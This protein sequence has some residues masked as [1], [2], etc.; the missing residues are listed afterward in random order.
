MNNFRLFNPTAIL[1]GKDQIENLPAEI[2]S[3][4][5]VLI[6]YG[7]GTIKRIGL[8]D[9][10]KDLLKDF[11]TGE[12][13]GIEPNPAYETLIRAVEIVKKEGYDFLLAVGGGSVIDGTKFIAAAAR[14]EGGD[15]WRMLSE[16]L[17]IKSVLPLGTVLTLPA[18]GSEM[19]CGAVISRKSECIKLDFGSPLLYPK[20]SILDPVYTYT[21]PE[22]QIGN[23]VVDTFIHVTEQYL[24][25]PV[26][27]KIQ[28][29]MA[30]GIL[31]TLIEDGPKAITDPKDYG[32]RANLMWAA[33][34]A[35]NDYIGV[36]VP[37]DWATHAIGHAIT[38][39]YG[40]D[41][42]RTLAVI[43][44]ALLNVM[45]AEKHDKLLQF[46][47]RVWGIRN[48]S[49]DDII[50]TAIEKTAAFFRSVGVPTRLSDYGIG[51][52][53]IAKIIDN[54][55]ET[56]HT[57]IGENGTITPDTVEKILTLAL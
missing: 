18:T 16:K 24:T 26:N 9:R 8:L 12:F 20:F 36:G 43:L 45:K 50:D 47:D 54:L 42:G 25:Y 6:T 39:L 51:K 55:R 56:G 11:Q 32:V 31:L 49:P 23:G 46:A 2:P 14:F 53:A 34:T 37:Q 3:G 1:F 44:P 52:D 38:A 33:T 17:E 30:E 28:D 41:H 29:R 57:V 15:P 7:G 4:S 5:K 27:A 10:V 22:R 35:L 13:G 21:L 40:V 19:N 48:G